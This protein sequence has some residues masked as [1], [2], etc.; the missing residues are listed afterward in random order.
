MENFLMSEGIITACS[1]HL[2][3][4]LPWWWHNLTAYNNYH[5][6]IFNLGMSEK[7]LSWCK[8]KVEVL[9][10]QIPSDLIV[11]MQNVAPEK[12]KGW[13]AVHGKGLWQTRKEWF[14]KPFAFASSPF[15]KT[16]WLDLDCEVRGELGPLFSFCSS[17][18]EI[19]MAKE[20]EVF[21]KAFEHFGFSLPGETIYNSGVVIYYPQ[22]PV[23]RLWANEAYHQN[24]LY[25]GDQEALSRILF[26][27]NLSIRD[28]P[29][30]YNWDRG[31]GASDRALI[32]HWHGKPGKQIL[33]E[34]IQ[35]LSQLGLSHLLLPS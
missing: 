29:S 33:H 4:M 14:K 2:E 12:A 22:N 1:S 25:L 26:K 19:A 24:H 11:D 28:L 21:Q 34:E 13:E 17:P 32:F 7:A 5:A 23:I 27:E 10:P 6:A 30:E 3:W 35:V 18:L 20:P 16:L 31:H 15:T 9:S 8:G